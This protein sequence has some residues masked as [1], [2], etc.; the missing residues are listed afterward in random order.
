MQKEGVYVD[1]F[2]RNF[3]RPYLLLAVNCK[4]SLALT[5]EYK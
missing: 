5:T 3:K 1:K 4:I 2:L